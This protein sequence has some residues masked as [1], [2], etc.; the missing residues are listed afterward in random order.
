MKKC[1]YCDMQV[2]NEVAVCPYCASNEFLSV[3]G[4]CGAAYSG[5]TCPSCAKYQATHAEELQRKEQA[6]REQAAKDRANSGLVWKC[7]LTFFLPLIGGYFLV[8]PNVKTGPKV[9]ALVWSVMYLGIGISGGAFEDTSLAAI[10]ITC[11]LFLGPVIYWLVGFVGKR[12][13]Q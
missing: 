1:S 4:V 12:N 3:C 8:G 11:A 2:A 7:V 13:S 6:A 9:F 5:S 10:F